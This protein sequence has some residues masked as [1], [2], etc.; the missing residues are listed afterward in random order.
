MFVDS[1]RN[2]VLASTPQYDR[3]TSWKRSL[4]SLQLSVLMAALCLVFVGS[5]LLA[6]DSN[7]QASKESATAQNSRPVSG[8]L[9]DYSN[10]SPDPNNADLLLYEKSKDAL[11][12]YSKFL[13]DPVTL[14]LL[15]EASQ[16]GLDPDDLERLAQ[17]FHDIIVDELTKAG[18]QVVS[19]PGPGVLDIRLAITNVEPSGAK[20]NVAAKAGATAAS[21]AVAPGAG[22]ALPRFSVGKASIEGEMLDS[23]SGER[24]GA[25]VTNKSGRRWFAGLQGYKTWGDVEAAFRTWAKNFAKRVDQAHRA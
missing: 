7:Q 18:Y 5:T 20:K 4:S 23:V 14:Y 10:L 16:R 2:V 1:M 9:G 13:I 12:D 17:R 22:L 19:S 11:K 3:I 8:F 15:P 6:Q 21:V 24:L 25:F